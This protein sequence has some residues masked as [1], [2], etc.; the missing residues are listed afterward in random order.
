MSWFIHQQVKKILVIPMR[1][2]S[3]RRSHMDLITIEEDALN[4]ILI[5][6]FE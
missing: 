5:A 3:R 4:Q 1:D 6:L 2:R